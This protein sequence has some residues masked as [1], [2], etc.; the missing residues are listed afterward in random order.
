VGK[1]YS[2][3]IESNKIMKN[4]VEKLVFEDM[5]L[6]ELEKNLKEVIKKCG[7]NSNVYFRFDDKQQFILKGITVSKCDCCDVK[8]PIIFGEV[9][10]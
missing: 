7:V 10:K 5:T 1:L 2:K 9:M 3:Y 6:G 4:T 8:L